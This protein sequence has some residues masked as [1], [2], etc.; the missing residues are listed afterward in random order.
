MS[1]VSDNL[2]AVVDAAEN[3]LSVIQTVGNLPG[4]DLIPYV[5]TV[6][7]FLGY[8]QKAIEVGKVVAPQVADFVDTFSNGLPPAEKLAA[9][10]ARIAANHAAIQGFTPVAEE[11]EP[12]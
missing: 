7:K 8:A 1:T 12:E 4:V 3:V 2:N 10:D 9:L 6:T 5:S 11:G